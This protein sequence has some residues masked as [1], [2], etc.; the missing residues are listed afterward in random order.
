MSL[1]RK[2]MF[3][4]WM[5]LRALLTQFCTSGRVLVLLSSPVPGKIARVPIGNR[6]HPPV[7]PIDGL[8]RSEGIPITLSTRT[9]PTLEE[10]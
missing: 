2:G 3:S 9:A 5:R 7:D 6:R 10:S 4:Y 8:D 1:G